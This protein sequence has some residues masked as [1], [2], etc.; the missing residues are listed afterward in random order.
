[1]VRVL[2][3]RWGGELG[4]VPIMKEGD[5]TRRGLCAWSGVAGLRMAGSGSAQ[6]AGAPP[7]L[8]PQAL[9]QQFERERGRADALLAVQTDRAGFAA[10]L[11]A[12]W[13]PRPPPP[14]RPPPG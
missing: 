4:A 14:G 10:P 1:M 2:R 6:T 9:Q 8:D 13:G 3:R 11:A 7:A 12:Q 5:M